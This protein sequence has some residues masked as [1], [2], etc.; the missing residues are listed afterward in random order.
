MNDALSTFFS[1][2]WEGISL[3]AELGFIIM[4]PFLIIAAFVLAFNFMKS[5]KRSREVNGLKGM[6]N[7]TFG[8][9]KSRWFNVSQKYLGMEALYDR[10]DVRAI[11]FLSASEADVLHFIREMNSI[12]NDIRELED[13]GTS[14]GDRVTVVLSMKVSK[15]ARVWNKAIDARA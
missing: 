12:N 6:S 9:L 15:A 7:E 5:K 4:L 14:D 2:V 11:E 3:F 13:A 10:G 8:E 1:L